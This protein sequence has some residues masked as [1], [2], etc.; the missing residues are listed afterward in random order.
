LYT[1]LP[2]DDLYSTN[3]YQITLFSKPD[4]NSHTPSNQQ[5]SR[6]LSTSEST[7]KTDPVPLSSERAD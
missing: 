4:G 5:N 6:N 3:P 1:S 7:E 2:R